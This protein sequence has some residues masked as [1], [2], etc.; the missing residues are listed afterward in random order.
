MS[1]AGI[2]FIAVSA[3]SQ[4]ERVRDGQRAEFGGHPPAAAVPRP[5]P[6]AVTSHRGRHPHDHREPRTSSRLSDR[7]PAVSVVSCSDCS[8]YIHAHSTVD[9]GSFIVKYHAVSSIFQ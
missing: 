2:V 7:V 9:I 1:M 5:S 6:A 4:G 8:L 3:A